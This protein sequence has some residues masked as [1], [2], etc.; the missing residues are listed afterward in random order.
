M[1]GTQE[2]INSDI[3]GAKA[4]LSAKFAQVKN[5]AEQAGQQ[6]YEQAKSALGE[7]TAQGSEVAKKVCNQASSFADSARSYVQEYP[8]RSLA[9]AVGAGILFG[10]FKKRA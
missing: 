7:A 2:R 5:N 6:V 1:N 9:A 10:Y 3:N 8:F 4:D